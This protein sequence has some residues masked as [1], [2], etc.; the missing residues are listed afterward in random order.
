MNRVLVSTVAL[1]MVT[2]GAPFASA[3]EGQPTGQAAAGSAPVA[4]PA[5]PARAGRGRRGHAP[6]GTVAGGASDGA[7]A[8][9]GTAI[10][11][12][13]AAEATDPA[14]K[15]VRSTPRFLVRARELKLNDARSAALLRIADAYF[16]ATHIALIA[17]GGTRTPTRQAQLMVGKFRHNDDVAALYENRAA[18]AEIEKAY[19]D[20]KAARQSRAAI[21]R[22]IA[23]VIV[24]QVAR[25]IYI[26]KHLQ[27]GA[28]DIRSRGMTPDR[29]AAFRAAVAAEP[30]V[31]LLD[32]RTG[33]EPH[34]HLSL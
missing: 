9:A 19:Q 17:T 2:L 22:A 34:F 16:N 4:T 10:N 31:V 5:S 24:A 20:G 12:A 11:A 13:N 23:A 14:A 27:F 33:P 26:S 1:V 6:S 8:P 30:G 18:F 3:Q 15:R 32:E 28:V 21:E 29:E 25:G 7:A